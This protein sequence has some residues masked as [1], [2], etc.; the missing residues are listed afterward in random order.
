[1]ALAAPSWETYLACEENFNGYFSNSLGENAPRTAEQKRY[2]V[3]NKDWG[4][5]WAKADYRF[6]LQDTP[7]SQTDIRVTEI[8]PAT[9]EAKKAGQPLGRFKHEN[10]EV[11]IASDGHAVVY[12]GDD[13]RGDYLA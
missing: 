7:M 12:M 5:G 3:N 4:Y 1:M 8:N 13:E 10:A 9:G 11:V 2:G 6:D